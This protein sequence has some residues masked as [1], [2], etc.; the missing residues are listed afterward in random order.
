MEIDTI[1][2]VVKRWVEDETG[3]GFGYHIN[4]CDDLT[5]YYDLLRD[6]LKDVEK[7][8]LKE[9]ITGT[10]WNVD[11]GMV[12]EAEKIGQM[13]GKIIKGLKLI[14]KLGLRKI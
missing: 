12:I 4:H 11:G 10:A 6:M 8:G 1:I 13:S 5:E 2:E 7:N 9:R 14:L 3:V